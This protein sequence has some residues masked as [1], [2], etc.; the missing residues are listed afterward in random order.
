MIYKSEECIGAGLDLK[1][2]GGDRG[3][4]GKHD[5]VGVRVDHYLLSLNKVAAFPHSLV[6]LSRTKDH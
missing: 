1:D 5:V 4:E 2:Y 6:K 3:L